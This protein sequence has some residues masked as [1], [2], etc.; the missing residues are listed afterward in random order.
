VTSS[1]VCDRLTGRFMS[2]VCIKVLEIESD[3]CSAS[4][5]IQWKPI[6]GN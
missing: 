2:I 6:D 1:R 5:V 3:L 4:W